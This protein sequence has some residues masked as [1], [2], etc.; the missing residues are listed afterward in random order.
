MKRIY[1]FLAV[2][3]V[4]IAIR[5]PAHADTVINFA[6]S[7]GNGITFTQTSGGQNLTFSNLYVDSGYIGDGSNDLTGDSAINS[8][9]VISPGAGG[10]FYL[11]KVSSDGLTGYFASNAA[12]TLTI[13]NASSGIMHGSLNMIEIDT[14]TSPSHPNGHGSFAL[15]LVLSNLSFSSCTLVGCTNSALLQNFAALGNGSNSSNTLTFSF[16]SSTASNASSLLALSGTHGTTVEGTLDSVFDTV[17]PEPASL[18]LFGSCLL[19]AGMKLHRR[20]VRP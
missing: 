9:V 20:A 11:N 2:V 8:S 12:A 13:G 17:T 5:V 16:S 19:M 1:G 3:M 4:L 7:G 18:A 10:H 6:S 14:N 15:T